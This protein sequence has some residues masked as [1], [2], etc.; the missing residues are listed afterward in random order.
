MS[1]LVVSVAL[2]LCLAGLDL[3]ASVLAKEWS[4][5]RPAVWFW[6][7]AIVHLALFA[8]Y[9]RTLTLMQLT[10][11]TFGWIVLLQIGVVLVDRARYG[12]SLGAGQLTALVAML[13]LQ[14]YVM[15]AGPSPT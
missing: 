7:G 6:A 11:V 3:V 15:T 10:V 5:G 14:M 13:A 1:S 4:T 8:V 12:T 2:L 9:A